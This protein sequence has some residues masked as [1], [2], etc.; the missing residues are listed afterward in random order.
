[1]EPLLKYLEAK[2]TH[3]DGPARGKSLVKE[4]GLSHTSL[5]DVF[6]EVTK[7]ENFTYPWAFFLFFFV[8]FLFLFFLFLF[9]FLF[10]LFLFFCFF[11]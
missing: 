4:W 8:L 3:D 11:F 2:S 6:L 9:L 7:R 1:M 10:F 5:E